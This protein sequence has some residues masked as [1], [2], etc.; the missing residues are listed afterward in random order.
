MFAGSVIRKLARSEAGFAAYKVFS[1]VTVAVRGEIDI[2]AMSDAFDAVVQAHPVFDSHFEQA[3]DG[4]YQIVADDLLHSGIWVVD[5]T[6]GVQSE[7]LEVNVDQTVS[8]INLRLILREDGVELTLYVHHSVADGHH[9]AALL[10][11]LALRY[12][13]VVATGDPGPIIP[14]PAPKSM[15]D[16]L[17][18]RGVKMK[19]LP[20]TERFY[21]LLHAYDLPNQKP[22]LTARPGTVPV[23]GPVV[24]YRLSKEDTADLIEFS[25][26]NRLSLNTLVA[27]AILMTEWQV[28][29]TPHVPIPYFY[30]V[31]LR[32]F[33]NPPV[34]ATECSN[35]VGLGSYVA[36]IAPDTDIVDLAN[37]ITETFR[38]DL[39][40]GLILQSVL[41]SGSTMDIETDGLPPFV[42]CTDISALPSPTIAGMEVRDFRSQFFYASP[43]NRIREVNG[44]MYGTGVHAGQLV[45]QQNTELDVESTLKAIGSLLC[46]LSSEYG[47][48]ME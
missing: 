24:R 20:G 43:E 15:E 34:G 35:L 45:I 42:F 46:S 21:P 17:E 37:D 27:A 39:A 14:Q 41:Y 22:T 26:E 44:G 19:R 48:E 3:S 25:R 36:E 12:T 32:F 30:P 18:Q 5:G 33:L 13:N 28:R 11:E 10:E 38:G 23:A 31:D 8:L 40:S 9:L 16:V 4:S 29:D 2:D 47:W 6:N 7:D 1:A